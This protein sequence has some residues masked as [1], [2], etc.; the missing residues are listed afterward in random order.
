MC[1]SHHLKQNI[2]ILRTKSLESKP[3]LIV[4]NSEA[5]FNIQFP[6]T[7]IPSSLALLQFLKRL[8]ESILNYGK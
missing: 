1:V 2:M 8:L 4:D 7:I 5:S 6:V 3:G